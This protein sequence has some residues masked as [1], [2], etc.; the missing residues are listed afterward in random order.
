MDPSDHEVRGVQD[1]AHEAGDPGRD[2]GDQ[3]H[4]ATFQDDELRHQGG[5]QQASDQ[6][7]GGG[8]AMFGRVLQ[9]SR[10][11]IGRAMGTH[12][13][14]LEQADQDGPVEDG[15]N[16]DSAS[17]E[18]NSL[19]GEEDGDGV[20]AAEASHEAVLGDLA[21]D[22]LST[23]VEETNDVPAPGAGTAEMTT[24]ANFDAAMA[25]GNTALARRM[26]LQ[27]VESTSRLSEALEAVC[28]EKD[29]LEA[30]IVELESDIVK[31]EGEVIAL[32]Q[33]LSTK[34]QTCKT[35]QDRIKRERHVAA[36]NMIIAAGEKEGIDAVF[37]EIPSNGT[38]VT[39]F[40]RNGGAV[41]VG[42][43]PVGYITTR[44]GVRRR[45]I[46]LSG[47]QGRIKRLSAG[48]VID[49]FSVNTEQ[50]APGRAANDHKFSRA[51]KT[52][53]QAT[54]MLEESGFCAT[55]SGMPARPEKDTAPR[56]Q[57]IADI[58]PKFAYKDPIEF[59]E[60]DFM[61]RIC[62]TAEKC[63]LSHLVSVFRCATTEQSIQLYT[64]LV[65]EERQRRKDD[66][67]EAKAL[68]EVVAQ[69]QDYIAEM[70]KI[71]Y[72]AC[73]SRGRRTHL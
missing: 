56:I 61:H 32:S 10:S 18:I 12:P 50:L 33:D 71:V 20:H 58:A 7:E 68:E 14:A 28:A 45:T 21:H 25:A 4:V 34:E 63:A 1:E 54:E 73:T 49:A 62:K 51:M 43:A 24:I 59:E 60:E 46:A 41:A 47:T 72:G 17:S 70:V 11:M 2:E 53:S 5:D 23:Y 26:F 35:L 15:A 42:E 22:E 40:A 8:R 67:K 19:H 30:T 48:E 27:I 29:V 57:I 65:R 6:A 36:E 9:A 39:R 66:T 44:Q 38:D 64:T 13:G 55:S 3:G 52:L 69:D 31:K 16:F 37:D